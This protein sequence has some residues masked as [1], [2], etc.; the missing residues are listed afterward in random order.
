MKI[1]GKNSGF[2]LIELLVVIAII[3]ILAG[4]LLPALSK[5]KTKGQGIKCMNNGKQLMLAWRMYVEDSNDTLPY[6][7]SAGTAVPWVNG[8]L[9]FAAG[10]PENYEPSVNLH[11]SP[12]WS[13]AGRNAQIWKCPADNARVLNRQGQ[14]VPRVRSISMLNWVGGDGTNPAQPW[15]GW[16]STWTVYR[17]LSDMIDPGPANTFVFLDERESSI[18]DGFFVVDMTGYPS[19]TTSMPDLPASYHNKAA[20]LSFADGHS[21]VHRWKDAFTTQPVKKNESITALG[22]A[23]ANSQDV[24]WM[25]DHATRRK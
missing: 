13:Y 21:E 12:L 2:T 14:N 8:I 18:N 24:R 11:N 10:R 16:G 3:A 25:Q 6:A 7:Y 17:K 20:G 23:P 1:S 22:A 9:N 15:G 19:G 4:M 5:A